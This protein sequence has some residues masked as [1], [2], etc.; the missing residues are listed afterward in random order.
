VVREIVK[1]GGKAVANYNSVLDGSVIVQDAIQKFGR[2]DILVNNAG[3]LR[4]VSFK[5]MTDK[6][7]DDIDAVHVKGVSPRIPSKGLPEDHS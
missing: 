5:N 4:D 1:A 2:L 3:I 7:W 6:H